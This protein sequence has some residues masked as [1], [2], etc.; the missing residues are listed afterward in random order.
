MLETDRTFSAL[1]EEYVEVSLHH[2]PVAATRAGV[3]DYDE[4]FPDHSPAGLRARAAWLR[5][6]DQRL[7]ASVPWEELAIGPRVE[8]AFL[9]SLIAVERA[10]L[11]ELRPQ[12]SNPALAPAVALEGIYLLATRP[13]APLAERKEALLARLMAIPAYLEGARRGLE[14]VSAPG[15]DAAHALDLG[16]PSYVDQVVRDLRRSF[17]GEAE[18]IEHAGARARVGFLQYQ[19]QLDQEL[20]GKGEAPFACG[21]RWL[22]QL[23][24]R[25]HL[26]SMDSTYIES[27]A[28]QRMEELERELEQEAARLDASK[29]WREQIDDARQQHP[30]PLRLREAYEAEVARALHFVKEQTGFTIPPG[31]LAI[32]DTP[33]HMRPV[34]PFA[35]HDLPSPL[36][37]DHTGFLL[38]TP[39]DLGPYGD[40]LDQALAG[41]NDVAISML[42]A[43]ETWPGRHLQACAAMVEGSRLRH[44]A[45]SPLTRDGWA[46]EAQQLMLDAGFFLDPRARLFVLRDRLEAAVGAFIDVG[47]HARAMTLEQAEG[48]LIERADSIPAQAHS[49][50]RKTA[51]EPSGALCALVG[52]ELIGE[53][54]EE[55]R[56]GMRAFDA[57]LFNGELLRI[58]MLP[59]FLVREELKERLP[60]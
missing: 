41:H 15:L 13:F 45:A 27:D 23:I 47:I 33:D 36:E 53:L 56:R 26:L 2:D 52:S 39:V 18:R 32:L 7:V 51:L 48:L 44:L 58:G 31:G 5:D 57:A 42:V 28:R 14:K 29:P 19:E 55:W 8:F 40:A 20:R 6:I 22:N 10:A 1:S 38:V 43:R 59:L 21:E 49:I 37:T 30:E 3:H 35:G 25:R 24:E 16:G 60:I 12:S 54:R 4:Q 9:R 11:E 17:P 34:L 46:L 50:V